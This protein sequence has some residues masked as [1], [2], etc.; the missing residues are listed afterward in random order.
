[1]GA[2]EAARYG[3]AADAFRRAVL[4]FPESIDLHW[5][6]AKAFKMARRDDE[7]KEEFQIVAFHAEADLYPE[8]LYELGFLHLSRGEKLVGRPWLEQ[9][10]A[11]ME[12]LGR[13]DS[14]LARIAR[15]RL[16]ELQH[17]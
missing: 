11:T 7:A 16:A 13:S 12:R 1:M 4:L 2:F 9:Y 15:E 14:P 10:V 8:A 17:E 5:A 6:L 3:E